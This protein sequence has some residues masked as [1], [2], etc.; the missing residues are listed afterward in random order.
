MR[1]LLAVLFVISIFGAPWVAVNYPDQIH[2]LNAA[3]LDMAS[4]L[5]AIITHNPRTVADLQSKYNRPFWSADSVKVR[6]LV[7]PGHEPGYGGAEYGNIKERELAVTIADDLIKFLQGNSRYEV[8]TTRDDNAWKPEFAT[9]F[10]DHWAEIIDWTRSYHQEMSHLVSV[11]SI[12]KESRAKVYHNNARQ[13]V[14]LR[15]YG[16]TKWSNENSI[17]IAIHIH[18]NDYPGHVG[19]APGEHSG[20]AIY[21][22]SRQYLNSTTTHAVADT[23]FKRLT[24]Y[25]AVSDLRGESSGIVD[26]PELIAIGAN[27][28]ADAASMLIEYGYIYEPQFTNPDLRNLA[29]KDLAYQTYLGLQDFFEPNNS[30]KAGLVYDTLVLPHSW[31]NTIKETAASADAFALQTAFITDG[32]Y[33][34][35]NKDK[36]NC[37]RSGKIGPCTKTA[38]QDFQ[39]KYGITGENGVVGPKTLDALNRT[40]GIRAL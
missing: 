17:D 22:P 31:R 38:L 34:P 26:E 37:P 29:L 15:L 9:Y 25:N 3:F 28:T 33:P 30:A 32:V 23:I 24:K 8:F 39:K 5:A 18:L 16:I 2:Y 35:A 36:N 6:I 7:V 1:H 40:Y 14:A 19:N 10:K 20:L 13:D 21:V 27:N 12:K 4:Q 11:G